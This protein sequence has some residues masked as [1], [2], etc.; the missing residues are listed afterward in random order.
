MR[1]YFTVKSV[2]KRK[3]I[4]T[5]KEYALAS[6]PDTLRDLIA[7]IVI[8]QV[9]EFNDRAEGSQLL[10]FMPEEELT[11]RGE[12]GKIGFGSRV[13]DRQANEEEAVRA[14]WSAFEDGLYR[15]FIREEE[16]PELSSKLEL[17]DGDE[18]AFIKFTMLAGR[19]RLWLW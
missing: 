15:V 14:A 4:L 8:R 3:P 5:R 17:Q 1:I 12:E 16:V 11:G 7:D 18:A 13:D 9:R 6:A 2:G 19:T 10:S